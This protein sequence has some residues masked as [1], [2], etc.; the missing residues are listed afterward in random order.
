MASHTQPTVEHIRG[1]LAFAGLTD[2]ELGELAAI[3]T[4]VRAR[5]G[6]DVINENESRV[7]KQ[8]LFVLAEGHVQV[9]KRGREIATLGAP[10][11]F[12]EI[13][14]LTRMA[15][16]ATVRAKESLTLY[17]IGRDKLEKMQNEGNLAALKLAA[18]LA[19]VLAQRLRA[20]SEKIV[21]LLPIDKREE[22]SEFRAKILSEWSF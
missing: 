13:E 19:R 17:W 1:C 18:S 11:V 10:S 6:D 12:G 2:A 8:G 4:K 20:T 3:L 7:E 22:F 21:E 9:L 15:P 5:A 14:L 16:S